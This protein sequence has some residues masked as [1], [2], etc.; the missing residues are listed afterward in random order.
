MNPPLTLEGRAEAI[1]DAAGREGIPSIFIAMSGSQLVGSAA[2][3]QNDMDTKS[4]LS[5]WLAA[6]YVKEGSRHQ[7]IATEL[8][9]RCEDEAARQNTNIWYLYTGF[10]SKLYKKL[11]CNHME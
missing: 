6:V 2:L 11:C 10:A 7:G 4:D 8:I 5:S 3:V 1:A 9:V